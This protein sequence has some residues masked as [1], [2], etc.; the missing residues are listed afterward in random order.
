VSPKTIANN[1][2]IIFVAKNKNWIFPPMCIPA[3]FRKMSEKITIED[4]NNG[5]KGCK[6]DMFW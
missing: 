3:I 1:M 4:K 2:G 6:K 5:E